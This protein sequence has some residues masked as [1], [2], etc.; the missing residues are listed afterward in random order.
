MIDNENLEIKLHNIHEYMIDNENLEI[1]LLYVINLYLCY[2]III[3]QTLFAKSEIP[4]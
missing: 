3:V 1:K 2:N 4:I